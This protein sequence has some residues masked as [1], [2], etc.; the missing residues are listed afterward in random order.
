M[1]FPLFTR[2]PVPIFPEVHFALPSQPVASQHLFVPRYLSPLELLFPAQQLQ[3]LL[4][5]Q[6]LQVSKL[7]ATS[8]LS[9]LG[10]L[11]RA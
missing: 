3:L 9:C 8:R 1:P 7:P 5:P 6:I 4:A 2:P 10:S 11:D